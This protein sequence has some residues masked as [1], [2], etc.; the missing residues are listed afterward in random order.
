MVLLSTT[1]QRK[2]T[3][4]L[5]STY[6]P[7]ATLTT[8][9]TVFAIAVRLGLPIHHAD[10]SQAFV[11]ALLK[12]DGWLRLPPGVSINRDGKQHKVA[13]L[14]RALYGLRQA[15]QAFNK[16]S[17]SFLVKSLLDLQ[18]TQAPAD[19]CLFHY[20]N[21]ETETFILSLLK[22]GLVE[23]FK[24][25]DTKWENLSS[26][27]GININ[28][29]VRAGRLEMDI[30]QKAEKMLI[31][32]PVLHNLRMHDVPSSGTAAEIPESAASKHGETDI[33]I[34]NSYASMIGACIYMS[35]TVRN[36]ITFAVGKCARY[37]RVRVPLVVELDIAGARC[38]RV[39]DRR[40]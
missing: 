4:D 32:H 25:D 17:V 31:D 12:E 1:P 15:P 9:R 2:L 38:V 20:F 3:F 5:F 10:I 33:Y 14:L 30:E 37:S 28:Y 18:F 21:P 22:R 27:L 24:I 34:K 26:F 16:E 19:S 7:M 36:D 29:D 13:K 35:V 23:R 40:L 39:R 6:P 8:V 11:N